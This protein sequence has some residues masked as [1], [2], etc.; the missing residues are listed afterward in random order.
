MST[1][2]T[3]FMMP[4][5]DVGPQNAEQFFRRIKFGA[6]GL[7]ILIDHVHEDMILDHFGHDAVDRPAAGGQQSHDFGATRI[8]LERTFQGFDLPLEPANPVQE[9]SFFFDGV[10]HFGASVLYPMGY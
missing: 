6:R 9:L 4:S 5:L 7:S 3:V 2:D 10:R 1:H 8:G